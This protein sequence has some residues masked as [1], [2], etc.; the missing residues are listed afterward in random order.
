[1]VTVIPD[2]L[3]VDLRGSVAQQSIFGGFSEGT[4]TPSGSTTL[5]RRDQTTTASLFV[6][7]YYVQR[8]GA[9]GVGQLAY[10]LSYVDQGNISRSNL[11]GTT[12]I[13]PVTGL[14]VTTAR[15]RGIGNLLTQR[16]VATFT[17]GENLGRIQSTLTLSATQYDGSGPYRNA[18]RNE[19][20]LD[21]AYAITRTIAV[22]GTV[23]YQN[24]RFDTIPRTRVDDVLW[25]LGVRFAPTPE[26]F[27][28]V[29]Y[30][31]RDGFNDFAAD[32]SYQTT[33]RTRVFLR[34]S[35]GLST[36]LEES[37]N[38]LASTQV[39]SSGSTVDTATGRPVLGTAGNFFGIQ[40]NLFRLRR[41][42]ASG[43]LLLDRDVFT[44]SLVHE[45]RSLV[46]RSPTANL[47]TSGTSGSG[48]YSTL[49][50][51]HDLSPDL[52]SQVALQFGTRDDDGGFTSS[53]VNT[54]SRSDRIISASASLN[55]QLSQTISTRALYQISNSSG[56]GTGD[57]TQNLVLV[58]LR[59]TF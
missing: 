35:N 50:W 15:G 38:L 54:R 19:V 4:A 48:L 1:M 46:G 14:P 8:F 57:V 12:V 7:P 52:Q 9:Y 21:N 3:F 45:T 27:I 11:V 29:R 31:R 42:S 44:L 18:H 32:A 20:S 28:S 26:D 16:E 36:D 10:S 24:L 2:R 49:Q 56:N 47:A 51:Q 33:P 43:V 25:N 17:S 40:D 37:S 23:G 58:G 55:Y 59:K 5:N 22:L 53:G 30:G 6:S 34:Y 41:L 13:D 39:D